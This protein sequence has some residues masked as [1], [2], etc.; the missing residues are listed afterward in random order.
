MQWLLVESLEATILLQ[1]GIDGPFFVF[2]TCIKP[3]PSSL[4]DLSRLHLLS[5]TDPY[6]SNT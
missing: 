6:I 2:V 4:H 5:N 3:P 1:I